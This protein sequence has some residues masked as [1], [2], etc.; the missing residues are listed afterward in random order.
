MKKRLEIDVELKKNSYPG[1]FV[2]IE[3]IDGAGKTTQVADVSK[4]LSKKYAVYPTK[5]P[6]D[7]PIGKLIRKALSGSVEVP[8]VAF[9]YL[10]SADREAQQGEI[11]GE[12][13]KGKLV[14]MDRYVWSALAY[15]ILDHGFDEIEKTGKTLSVALSI[16]STYHQFLM[17][18]TTIYL[19]VPVDI[20][21]KRLYESKRHATELYK[22]KE[23]VEKA[24]KSYN[25]VVKTF[26]EEFTMLDG[27]LP[28]D[29]VT[30]QIVS[31]IEPLVK[32]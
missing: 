31:Y 16:L 30:R 15:G 7:G 4:I 8:Q 22:R 2:V 20:A 13:K 6:T 14:L 27:T 21:V 5:Q 19:N 11:I 12:L 3:G 24:K 9:Q 18:D 28:E 25:W 23:Q 32:K 26:S 29:E 10:F 1:K 17:P